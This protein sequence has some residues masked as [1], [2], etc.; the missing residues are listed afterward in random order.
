MIM[1]KGQALTGFLRA[2]P[3]DTEVAPSGVFLVSL[4]L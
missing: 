2:D 3:S 1:L 4:V